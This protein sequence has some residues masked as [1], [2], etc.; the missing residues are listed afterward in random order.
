MLCY[1]VK[2]GFLM[3]QKM[4]VNNMKKINGFTLIEVILSLVILGIVSLGGYALLSYAAQGYIFSVENSKVATEVKPTL[5]YV[6]TK[7]SEIEN[8]VCF[9][10]NTGIKFKDNAKKEH[11]VYINGNSLYINNWEILKDI[12]NQS[13]KVT[14]N[15]QIIEKFQLKFDYEMATGKLLTYDME[16]SPRAQISMYKL[17][18]CGSF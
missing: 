18:N 14:I 6:S 4:D 9:T 13:F 16:F 12:K 2:Q 5:D 17:E 7:M 1:I 11:S 8:L 10:Y 3:I 15:N